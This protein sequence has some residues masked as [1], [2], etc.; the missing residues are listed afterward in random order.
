MAMIDIKAN[1][2]RT[3]LVVFG[4]LWVVFFVVLAKIAFWTDRALLFAAA[5]T[6]SCFLI[7]LAFNAD[8]PKKQ[9]M[10]GVTIPALL[11]GIWLFEKVAASS[12]SAW[13][14][15]RHESWPFAG[16]GAQLLV[17][18]VVVA[19]ALL[20]GLVILA[21]RP[22]GAAIYRTWMF[23]ALPM[24]WTISHAVLGL[25]YYLVLTPVG[26]ALRATGK[27]PMERAFDPS[28]QTYWKPHTQQTR[29][30]R[31]FRQF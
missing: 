21:S 10:I 29:L 9:Q 15:A 4:I 18:W 22:A 5:F 17:L 25:A 8:F 1:P 19:L 23:A 14:S 12:G 6:F 30:D 11:A 28:V 24:G 20:G 13:V 7:S 3:D 16:T 26:L 2:S 27:D 31:Y